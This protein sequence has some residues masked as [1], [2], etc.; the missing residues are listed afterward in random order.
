M[1]LDFSF[2]SMITLRAASKG[3][4]MKL[5]LKKNSFLFFLYK[6]INFFQH[7]LLKELAYLYKIV[8]CIFIKN[9]RSYFFPRKMPNVR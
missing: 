2:K 7:Y 8:H 9:Q 5:C 1:D 3:Y 4:N 6:N